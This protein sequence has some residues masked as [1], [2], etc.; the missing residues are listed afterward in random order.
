MNKQHFIDIFCL[1]SSVLTFVFVA[2]SSVLY[3]E[4]IWLYH[5]VKCSLYGHVW[6][7]GKDLLNS[8]TGVSN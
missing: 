6:D 8:L 4:L 7:K 2:H 1:S 3:K 5:T